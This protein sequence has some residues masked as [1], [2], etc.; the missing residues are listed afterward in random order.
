MKKIIVTAAALA[1]VA[2]PLAVTAPAHAASNP[3]CASRTEF[4]R[5]HV[6]QSVRTTQQII[7]SNGRLTMGGS[8]MSQRQWRACSGSGSFWVTLTYLN[9]RLNNKIML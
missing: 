4:G 7:G 8:F 3:A 2:T 6:G 9:G 1:A 5:I